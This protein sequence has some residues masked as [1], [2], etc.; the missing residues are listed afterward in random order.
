[1]EIKIL[2]VTHGDLGK[3]ISDTAME[4]VGNRGGVEVF[5]I[6][7]HQ[8]VE[9]IKA[10]L[11]SLIENMLNDSKLLIFTDMLGGTPT[12]LS[13]PFLNNNSVEIITGVNLPML[14]TALHKRNDTKDIKRL[15]DAVLEA[16]KKSLVN[17]RSRG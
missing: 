12:N 14:I 11:N 5:G 3:V 4:I 9:E 6:S 15:A 8:R 17:C 16:G 10:E 7:R 2:I 1:M 13:M